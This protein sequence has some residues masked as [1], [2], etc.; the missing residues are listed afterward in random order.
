MFII[1]SGSVSCLIDD[2]EVKTLS[3]GQSFGD[4][5]VYFDYLYRVHEE[6]APIL[7][8]SGALSAL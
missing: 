2:I 5:A 1:C 6:H 4:V 8:D 3:V 7:G